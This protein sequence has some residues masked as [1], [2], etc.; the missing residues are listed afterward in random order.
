[1]LMKKI[2]IL[3]VVA[4]VLSGVSTSSAGLKIYYIRHAE[5]GHNV[6]QDWEYR[7]VPKDQWPA[8][9]GDHNAFTPKGLVQ[10]AAVAGQLKKFDIDFIAASP[11]WRCQ[12][13][14]L[15]YMKETGSKGEIW[16]ELHELSA[17][18]LI[19]STD[20]PVPTEPILG[21]GE[22]IE[23]PPEEALYFT[24]REDGQRWFEIS[25]SG[26]DREQLNAAARV[27]IQRVVDMI[28][29]RFGGTDKTILLSGHGS[30]GQAVLRML[31]Q[32][33]LD[34]FSGIA[35]TGI[36]M[37]E[38]QPDGSFKLILYNSYPLENGKPSAASKFALMDTNGDGQ[39][40]KAEYVARHASGFK[41][42]DKNN[43][44]FLSSD[45]HGHSSF[46]GA[47]KNKD[48]QLS[49]EEYAAI[50][51][52]QFDHSYDKNGDGIYTVGER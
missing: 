52:E 21:A 30:S 4:S 29:D 41:R 7:K 9:V 36:W 19:L 18:A 51:E 48:N 11:A 31:T 39:V 34:E 26:A 40:T 25:R 14:I 45:E 17:N 13:T 47:D 27:V 33:P 46:K 35:N 3:I 10:Q 22:P 43:D 38:E 37:V 32:D 12:N 42:K 23:L 24:V 1:M 8:Y 49:E 15:P 2:R 44:G 6:K 16:P 28:Q 50:F 5:G 20:L